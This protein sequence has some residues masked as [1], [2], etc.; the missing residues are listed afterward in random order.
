MS[1]IAQDSVRLG[2]SLIIG[3]QTVREG[4]DR[5]EEIRRLGRMHSGSVTAGGRNSFSSRG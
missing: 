4:L 2:L 5:I 1:K 3:W